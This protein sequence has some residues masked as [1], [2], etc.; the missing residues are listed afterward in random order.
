MTVL[1]LGDEPPGAFAELPPG[2]VEEEANGVRWLRFPW[3]EEWAPCR[4]LFSCRVGGCSPFPWNSLNL[5][6]TVH[7]D[8]ERVRANRSRFYEAAGLPGDRAVAVHQVHGRRHFH[9]TWEHFGVG[10]W[11]DVNS[12]H[13][14]DVIVTRERQMPLLGTF[15][16]CVPIYLAD[17][18]GRGIALAHA[19][20]RGTVARVAEEAVV[21]LHE[22]FG[23]EPADC[24]ALIGPS[25][26]P[27]CYQVGEMVAGAAREAL[28][29]GERWLRPDG[30]NHYRFDLWR[31][32][33]AVLRA[34][35]VPEEQIQI[36][37][38]CTSCDHRRLFSHRRGF[39]GRT[40]RMLAVLMLQ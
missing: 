22:R 18:R 15:A 5:G 13:G 23:I 8:P 21:A 1:F 29:H 35:G 38:L 28:P 16:D 6:F 7:D 40:G 39:E 26:G 27:C 11:D 36:A 2:C 32:N 10:A 31:A 34:A 24:R 14:Y 9:A 12:P 17:R 4:A 3:I 37:G 30:P 19:G 20:W 33:H 25:I